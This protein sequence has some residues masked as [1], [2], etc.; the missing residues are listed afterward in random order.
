MS[1]VIFGWKKEQNKSYVT[2]LLCFVVGALNLLDLSEFV[3]ITR[4]KMLRGKM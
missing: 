1:I 3:K 4:K 2:N